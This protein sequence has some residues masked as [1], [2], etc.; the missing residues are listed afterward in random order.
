MYTCAYGPTFLHTYLQLVKFLT[1][2]LGRIFFVDIDNNA[3]RYYFG[4]ILFSFFIY[5]F[6]TSSCNLVSVVFVCGFRKVD[7][8]ACEDGVKV[9]YFRLILSQREPQIDYV[10]SS[11]VLKHYHR[12]LF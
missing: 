9:N 10:D 3:L 7:L 12:S 5:S 11:H 4:S 1:P 6:H 2:L 8:S